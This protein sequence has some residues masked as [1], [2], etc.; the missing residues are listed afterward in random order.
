MVSF[1]Y[2]ILAGMV[3]A[4]LIVA[5][6]KNLIEMYEDKVDKRV[7]SIVDWRICENCRS[8]DVQTKSCTA[9]RMNVLNTMSCENWRER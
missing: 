3:V 6:Y 2:G 4:F 7:K 1:F 5:G 8:Y 9:F